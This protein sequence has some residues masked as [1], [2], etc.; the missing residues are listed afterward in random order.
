MNVQ[1]H[2]NQKHSFRAFER[3]REPSCE[4]FRQNS[5]WMSSKPTIAELEC[6]EIRL[7]TKSNSF[8]SNFVDSVAFLVM[9]NNHISIA[10]CHLSHQNSFFLSLVDVQYTFNE[11]EE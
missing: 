1:V 3:A 7:R 4:R 11:D 6:S 2:A 5:N 10:R 8:K 9:I